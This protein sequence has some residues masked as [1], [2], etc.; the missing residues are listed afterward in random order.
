MAFSDFERDPAPS[1]FT[2]GIFVFYFLRIYSGSIKYCVIYVGKSTFFLFNAKAKSA[3]A[4][5]V[6][7]PSNK[8]VSLRDSLT[9][10]EFKI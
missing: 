8:I 4:T 10:G 5:S 7:L 3:K 2:F 9:R 1:V 6:S